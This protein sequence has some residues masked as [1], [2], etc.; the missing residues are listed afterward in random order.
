MFKPDSVK[1]N[2]YHVVYG[3]SYQGDESDDNRI[4]VT[5]DNVKNIFLPIRAG[6]I[7]GNI[8]SH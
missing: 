8:K 4:N 6:Y 3:N 7:V 1:D 5:V 2:V